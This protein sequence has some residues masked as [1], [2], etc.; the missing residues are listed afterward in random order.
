M[1]FVWFW[2]FWHWSKESFRAGSLLRNPLQGIAG[3]WDEWFRHEASEGE[4]TAIAKAGWTEASQR[5]FIGWLLLHWAREAG[6]RGNRLARRFVVGQL[7]HVEPFNQWMAFEKYR[8]SYGGGG[9][10]AI[11][12]TEKSSGEP[13]DVRLVE[14]IALPADA[15]APAVVAE[16]FQADSIE[17]ET[18]RR[19]AMSLLCG[20]GFLVFL[21]LWLAAGRRPYPQWLKLVL[22]LGWLVAGALVLYLLL[23][24][25]AGERLR[26][27]STTLVVLW[28]GLVLLAV[29]VVATQGLRA[30][31]QGRKWSARLRQSQVRLRMNGGLT[32]KG[33]SAGL[34]FCLNTLLSL[35][36]AHPQAARRSWLWLRFFRGLGS[37]A[38][39]WAATGVITSQGRLKPVVLEPKLRAC[40]QQGN[41][42]H[43][44]TPRQ[45]GAGR[46]A[47]KSLAGAPL[48]ADRQGTLST[49]KFAPTQLG[50]AA[51]TPHLRSHQCR[52]VAQTVMVLGDLFSTWQTS[53][54]SFAVIASAAI[55]LAL[56]DLHSIIAPPP[57]PTAVTP[58]SPSPYYLWVSLN[59][60]KPDSFYVVLESKFWSNRRTVVKQYGGANASVRAE[61]RLQ[62]LGHQISSIE[63]DGTV[64]IERRRR[65]LTREFAP[66]ERVGRYSLSYLSHL[67]Y[68]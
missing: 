35:H 16:G 15:T 65:F 5:Q 4:R 21:A 60:Q 40:L 48:R 14:A 68:E 42:L 62:R 67:G 34:A 66:G 3:H 22:G 31:H 57:A 58:S 6:L 36:R 1:S 49:P 59:T 7:A 12:L 39:S 56:P 64:W 27:L 19:A 26:L 41:I 11:V 47:I 30:W 33:G 8:Q 63:A 38:G 53:V 9:I 61:I 18:P 17:L 29:T 46:R 43:V 32:L 13:A 2:T 52:H 25:D 51:E 54:N 23:G 10:S 45:R 37:Q 55:L 20:K 50:F 28:S 44:L 24:A